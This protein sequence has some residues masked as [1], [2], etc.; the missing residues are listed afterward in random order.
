MKYVDEFRD[1]EVARALVARINSAAARIAE[2]RTGPVKI[3]EIC[4]SHT[5]S[6]FRAGIKSLLPGNVK[7]VSGP[8]CPVCVTAME[9]MDRMISL[10][11]PSLGKGVILATFGDMIR[12]P[13]TRTSLE[14]EKARGCDVRIAATPLD[15]LKWAGE[16]PQKQVVFLGVGF[17]TTSPT[18][19]ASVLRARQAGLTNFTVYPAFKLLPPALT[20][21]LE[22]PGVA[23]D[24][25]LCPGHVSVMLGADAYRPVAEKYR[26][27]CVIAGF[28][29]VD[30]LLGISVLCEQLA[31]HLHEV[32][33]A[34]GRAVTDRGNERAMSL[35][36]EV[37]SPA[38]SPW[39]G[40]GTIP[41]SG[42]AFRD[43]FSEFD[44]VKRFSLDKVEAGSEPAGCAC[45][46]VL[47]G[48]IDPVDCPLFGSECTPESPVG[49]C[50]VSSEGSCAAWYRYSGKHK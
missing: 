3:M 47:R 49:S 24:G 37:F 41:R 18:I 48:M 36:M 32:R 6:I 4:G 12:V 30:I 33:N 10:A 1:P 38:D 43:D 23:L 25:F 2:N 21:L 17:E 22:S 42:L 26:K 45:G 16:N 8:G 34:Y 46:S 40:L 27:P 9:D 15:A 14:R 7:L 5:V 50:M 19:G 44:A 11:D 28:E 20:A 35:L 31:H 13:G 29:P 39:R